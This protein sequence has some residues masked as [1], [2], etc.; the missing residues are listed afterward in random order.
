[1]AEL[2][3]LDPIPA[4]SE[5]IV[6]EIEKIYGVFYDNRSLQNILALQD[7]QGGIRGGTKKYAKHSCKLN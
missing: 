1:M 6:D 7:F 2:C 5:E 3:N 4:T